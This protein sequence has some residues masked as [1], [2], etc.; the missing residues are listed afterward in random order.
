[1]LEIKSNGKVEIYE[2]EGKIY[3][4]IVINGDDKEISY[5]TDRLDGFKRFE[6]FINLI[7]SGYNLKEARKEAFWRF[8]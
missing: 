1:M 6:Y 7:N 8:P 4:K 5:I 2:K 3:K